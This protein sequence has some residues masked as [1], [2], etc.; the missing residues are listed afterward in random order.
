M[1]PKKKNLPTLQT[2]DLVTPTMDDNTKH[3]L[4]EWESVTLDRT[5]WTVLVKQLEDLLVLQGLLKL[6]AD[7]AGI[8][9]QTLWET[10]A[11]EV[12]VKKV[13]DGG[14]GKHLQL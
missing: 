7:D 8:V 10:E 4:S 14:R 6:K 9:S 12:T 2:Q 1:V 11:V 5:Q 13:M 3:R